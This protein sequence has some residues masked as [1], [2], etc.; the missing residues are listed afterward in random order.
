MG[1]TMSFK[2]NNLVV[3]LEQFIEQN[4]K[5]NEIGMYLDCATLM[6]KQK[7][8]T[9]LNSGSNSIDSE[10]TMNYNPEPQEM[11]VLVVHFD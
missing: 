2:G 7:D 1:A 11:F 3:C 9:W 10:V 4:K 6:V 5:A 8:G